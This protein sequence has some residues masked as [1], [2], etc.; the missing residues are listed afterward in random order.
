VHL[1]PTSGLALLH[2]LRLGAELGEDEDIG[3]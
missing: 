2:M 1:R 3:G